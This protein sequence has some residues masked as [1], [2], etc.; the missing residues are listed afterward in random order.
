M[1]S[2]QVD[3]WDIETYG[4]EIRE[5]LDRH[6]QIVIRYLNR[7]IELD[8]IVP[9]SDPRERIRFKMPINEHHE[10]YQSALDGLGPIMATKTFRAFHYSRMTD[11]EAGAFMAD[12]INLTSKDFLRKRVDRQVDAGTMS[13]VQGD[14]IVSKTA[15]AR[16]REF[17]ERNGFWTT[18]TPIHPDD[19]AVNMLVGYW[20]GESAYWAFL[21]ENGEMIDLLKSTGRGRI[22]EIAVPLSV[23]TFGDTGAGTVTNVFDEFAISLGY[24]RYPRNLD[25]QL[26]QPLPAAAILRIHTEGDADYQRFG[27][28]YPSTFTL[29]EK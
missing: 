29:R 26:V 16:P 20:G 25:L 12:G 23:V 13:S 9:P 17:G 6:K 14:L 5:Y 24:S 15:L 10:E 4:E 19:G 1:T 27:A 3:V 2:S 11:D 21:G 8:K 18:A 28:G 22:L 7:E